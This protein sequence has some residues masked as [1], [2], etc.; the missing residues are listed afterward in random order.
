MVTI[1]R[2]FGERGAVSR[3]QYGQSLVFDQGE[4]TFENVDE[5]IFMAVP[6]TL[7]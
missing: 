7:T 3:M 2:A 4:L 5:L 1:P 6:V